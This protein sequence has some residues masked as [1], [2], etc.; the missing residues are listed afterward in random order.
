MIKKNQYLWIILIL[1]SLFALLSCK[2]TY[3]YVSEEV[4]DNT[5]VRF[6]TKSSFYTKGKSI[7]L[8]HGGFELVPSDSTVLFIEGQST[9]VGKGGVSVAQLR[10]AETAR[11]YVT[12]PNTINVG[13]YN[14][15][16]KAICEITGNL[17]YRIGETLF[18]CQRGSVV[19]DSLVGSKI[20]GT[21]S[22]DYLNTRNQTLKIE[23][24][25]KAGQK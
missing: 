13:K 16:H 8:T 12:L 25:I 10:L 22:G 20:Y 11:F 15:G 19:V 21:I 17:N 2:K 18:T 3:F 23:G 14:I 5:S 6:T 7:A 1:L 4:H 9:G 24:N